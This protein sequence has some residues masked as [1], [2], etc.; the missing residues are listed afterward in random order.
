MSGLQGGN[1]EDLDPATP[2]PQ[3]ILTTKNPHRLSVQ[4]EAAEAQAHHLRPA[5][6][7]WLLLLIQLLAATNT[8]LARLLARLN[9]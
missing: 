3:M 7:Q 6:G 4:L 1:P 9:G 2:E 5:R 8:H